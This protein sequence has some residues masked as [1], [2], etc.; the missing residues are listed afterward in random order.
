MDEQKGDRA[1]VIYRC[2]L[3]G[4]SFGAAQ[5]LRVHVARKHGPKKV[6]PKA[7]PASRPSRPAFGP[8]FDQVAAEIRAAR[9]L[10]CQ[11]CDGLEAVLAEARELRLALIKRT[12]QLR[13]LK[14]KIPGEE[15]EA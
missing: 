3:G 1:E 2:N 10:V 6:R 7:P 4:R 14:A 5:A 11:A 9:E 12:D 8:V 13:K 15:K